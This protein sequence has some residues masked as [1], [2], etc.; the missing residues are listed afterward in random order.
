M[1]FSAPA[2]FVAGVGLLL[3]G[4]TAVVKSKTIPQYVLSC[5][6]ILFGLQQGIEGMVWLG[7]SNTIYA[8]W[9]PY[10]TYLFLAFAQLVWPILVP[11]SILLF[12]KNLLRRKI[13]FLFLG[14]GITTALY[15]GYSLLNYEASAIIQEHHIRYTLDFPFSSKLLRGI[16][17]MLATAVSP[18]FS[19]HRSL[20][21]LGWLLVISYI[22][23]AIV[24]LQYLTSVWCYF[25]AILSSAI[26]FIV[27]NINRQMHSI[28]QVN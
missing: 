7:L 10:A 16:P 1:C 27:I 6:P 17:Y 4:G 14:I 25:G 22:F 26:L 9:L 21:L 11:L 5:I 3:V 23:T 18:F 13:L 19:S 12:E 28:K 8:P 15:L 24:Y 20:R 2:S